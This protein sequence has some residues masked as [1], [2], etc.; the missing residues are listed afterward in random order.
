[1]HDSKAVPAAIILLVLL[2]LVGC[3]P[4]FI[5]PAVDPVELDVARQ[6]IFETPHPPPAWQARLR[7]CWLAFRSA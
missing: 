3:G 6:A 2:P 4:R 5:P 7:R 1:M